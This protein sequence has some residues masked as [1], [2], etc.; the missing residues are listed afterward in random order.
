MNRHLSTIDDLRQTYKDL[1]LLTEDLK[2]SGKDTTEV[3]EQKKSIWMDIVAEE[4]RIREETTM[5]DEEHA[6]L[7]RARNAIIRN[8]GL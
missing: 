6:E 3:L 8:D 5:T 4:G 7:C 2:N 1:D